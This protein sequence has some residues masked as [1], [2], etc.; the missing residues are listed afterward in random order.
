MK[1]I[2]DFLLNFVKK[3]INLEILKMNF[4]RLKANLF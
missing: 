3:C 2:G 1:N 4:L